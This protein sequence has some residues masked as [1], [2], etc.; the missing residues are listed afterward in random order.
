MFPENRPLPRRFMYYLNI[1]ITQYGGI[2]RNHQSEIV[3]DLFGTDRNT[4]GPRS[5]E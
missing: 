3:Y 5:E 2:A 1:L 4:Y